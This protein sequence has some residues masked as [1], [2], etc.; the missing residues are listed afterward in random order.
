MVSYVNQF[1][2]KC[3]STGEKSSVFIYLK[4]YGALLQRSDL[5]IYILT[6]IDYGDIYRLRFQKLV[7]IIPSVSKVF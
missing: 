5:L 4:K 1:L 6:D 3:L 2:A 7:L